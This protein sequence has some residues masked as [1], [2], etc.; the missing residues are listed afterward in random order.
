MNK[1]NSGIARNA[2]FY[3]ILHREYFIRILGSKIWKN[4]QNGLFDDLLI[5]AIEMLAADAGVQRE[6]LNK[7][8]TY[9]CLD[10]LALEFDD[11][12]QP[13]KAQYDKSIPD[14]I[15]VKIDAIDSALAL[16]S[17]S[18]DV[19]LWDESSLDTK[20]WVEVR[21]LA[22]DILYEIGQLMDHS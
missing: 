2:L 3:C 5:P 16:L 18:G 9:P 22:R 15:L 8:G 12:Y 14:T 6:Y 1:K 19:T 21:N 10:E 20:P 17:D 4:M 7:L 11:A 13:F